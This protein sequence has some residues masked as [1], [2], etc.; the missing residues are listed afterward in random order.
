LAPEITQAVVLGQGVAGILA[1]I[2][3]FIG[4]E[5][6]FVERAF[7][8][9]SGVFVLAGSVFI[10]YVVRKDAR[11]RALQGPP[12]ATNDR[13]GTPRRSTLRLLR[14]AVSPLAFSVF[15]VLVVTFVVFPEVMSNWPLKRVSSLIAVYQVV[16]VLGRLLLEVP[17]LRTDNHRL[18][19]LM[20]ALRVVFIPLFIVVQRVDYSLSAF[21]YGLVSVFALSNGFV[22]CNSMR[23]GPVQPGIEEDEQGLAAVLMNFFLGFGILLG[24]TLALFTQYDL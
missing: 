16:D 24:S 21:Q 19:C 13:L 22:L 9:A 8:M 15:F 2:A 5:Y 12:P 10:G 6:P 23:L 20:S 7:L 4:K 14:E 3:G 18:V 11:I 1:G 17:V